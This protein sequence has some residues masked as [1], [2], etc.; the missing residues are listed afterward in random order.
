M[1]VIKKIFSLIIKKPLILVLTTEIII[2]ILL[3][4]LGFRITYDPS[5]INDWD[6]IS[7][8]GTWFCGIVIP[9]AVVFIQ[10]QITKN[11]SNVNIANTALLQEIEKIKNQ[12]PP[13]NTKKKVISEDD[14]YR[15]ICIKIFTTTE[16]IAEHFET[17]VESIRPY[18]EEMYF[19]KRIIRTYSLEDDP[20]RNIAKCNWTRR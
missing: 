13:T 14:I 10:H 2:A 17:D 9:I 15:F 16:Q 1:N 5:L 3:Y 8:C 7:A 6:A 11:E 12:S 18:L 4:C 20:R 19:V